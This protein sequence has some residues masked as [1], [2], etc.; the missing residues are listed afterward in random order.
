MVR[1]Q[2]GCP[3]ITLVRVK[4]LISKAPNLHVSHLLLYWGKSFW[5]L[6]K[7]MSSLEGLGNYQYIG[8]VGAA[9]TVV[10]ELCLVHDLKAKLPHTQ[11]Q[12]VQCLFVAP[13]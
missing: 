5:K 8:W 7:T 1:L 6:L 13:K 3:S 4:H 11:V 9:V 2:R 10:C 12:L